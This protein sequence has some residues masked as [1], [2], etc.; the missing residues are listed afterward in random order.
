MWR[1]E[2]VIGE[3]LASTVKLALVEV[4]NSNFPLFRDRED[5]IYCK[6][7]DKN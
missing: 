7:Y 1:Q 5:H 6:E 4:K 2:D 3:R